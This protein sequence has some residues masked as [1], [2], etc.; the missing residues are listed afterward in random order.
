MV[1]IKRN[2]K[3]AT[4]LTLDQYQPE[5]AAKGLIIAIHGG[6]WFQGDKAKEADVSQWLA[7]QGYL[8]VT[9]NYRLAPTH[10]FPAPLQDMNALYDW[11]CQKE[12]KL[13]IAAIG[14]SSGGNLAVELALNYGIPAVSLSGILD[15]SHWLSTHPLVVAKKV[16][17]TD[18]DQP[19]VAVNQT[20]TNDSFYKWFIENYLAADQATAATPY[21]HVSSA[22]GPMLLI[23]SLA[24]FVPITGITRLSQRLAQVKVPVETMLLPGSQH[25]KGY[26]AT[27]QAD[28]L[29]FLKRYL[30]A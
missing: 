23:N 27:V 3:Y 17:T 5:Q 19:S 29:L 4:D 24:E 6:G 16:A 30:A 12:P 11:L 21:L 8:V 18:P 9:P 10:L 1:T 26:L 20:G 15:I 7:Q 13:P 2:I 14:A 25:G 28:I 22:S